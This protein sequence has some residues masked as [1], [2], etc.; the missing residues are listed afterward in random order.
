[1]PATHNHAGAQGVCLSVEPGL[2]FPS[3]PAFCQG[4]EPGGLCSAQSKESF[5]LWGAGTGVQGPL[6]EVKMFWGTKGYRKQGWPHTTLLS[7]P[8][9]VL[10]QDYGGCAGS[11]H[12]LFTVPASPP[13][14]LTHPIPSV[15][16]ACPREHSRDTRD[17]CEPQHCISGGPGCGGEAGPHVPCA[18]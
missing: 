10:T 2:P 5:T 14:A 13:F 8:P 16:Q 9:H 18:P 17:A 7:Q 12:G 15:P 1:M 6:P 3:A 4:A 11:P